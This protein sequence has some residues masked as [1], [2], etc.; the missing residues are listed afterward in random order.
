LR[1]AAAIGSAPPP[2]P[3]FANLSTGATLGLGI[4]LQR[5]GR[6]RAAEAVVRDL[7]AYTARAREQ[8]P[9]DDALAWSLGSSH[10]LLGELA[11]T[12]NRAAEAETHYRNALQA[13]DEVPA[14]VY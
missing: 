12:D 7:I 11:D 3:G 2:D 5:I 8:F 1:R 14:A 4:A 13:Y 10:R 6:P 9:A